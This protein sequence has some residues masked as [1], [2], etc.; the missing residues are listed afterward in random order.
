MPRGQGRSHPWLLDSA[1]H[2]ILYDVPAF[3]LKLADMVLK[4]GSEG[5]RKGSGR[6]RT[7]MTNKIGRNI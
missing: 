5:L 1:G 6:I 4:A 2:G 3:D 7:N